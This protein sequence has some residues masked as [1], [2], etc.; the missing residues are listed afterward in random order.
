MNSRRWPSCTSAR[1]RMMA[2]REQRSIDVS[3]PP[4][5]AQVAHY[6]ELVAAIDDALS[7]DIV[8]RRPHGEGYMKWPWQ[9]YS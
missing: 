2:C 1:A 6:R 9:V 5:D 4:P 3:L 7:G 8:Q